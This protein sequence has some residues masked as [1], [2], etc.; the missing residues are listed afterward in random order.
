MIPRYKEFT[1][2]PEYSHCQTL[3]VVAKN[4]LTQGIIFTKGGIMKRTS[5][6]DLKVFMLVLISF[7]TLMLYGGYALA[8]D[9]T[10]QKNLNE[11]A[12]QLARWSKQS[13]TGKLTAEAQV[14]LS[15]LLLETSQVLKEMAMTGG[16]EMQMEHHNKIQMMKKAWDPFDNADRM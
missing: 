12:D 4:K 2:Y 11:V 13:G 6:K 1:I 9:Q 7:F 3:C 16:G 15:A 5:K 8:E 10:M 14:K